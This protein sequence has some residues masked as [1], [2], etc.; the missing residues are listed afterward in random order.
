MGCYTGLHLQAATV[1]N[2]RQLVN[3]I[4]DFTNYTS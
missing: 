2:V 1:P 3:I 4:L